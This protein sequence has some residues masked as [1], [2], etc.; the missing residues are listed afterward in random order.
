[1]LHFFFCSL[2]THSVTQTTVSGFQLI[3]NYFNF[4]SRKVSLFRL[5]CHYWVKQVI[6]CFLKGCL[7]T[8]YGQLK[9]FLTANDPECAWARQLWRLSTLITDC[10]PCPDACLRNDYLNKWF[11]C[12]KQGL[13]PLDVKSDFGVLSYLINGSLPAT[14]KLVS[15]CGCASAHTHTHTHTHSTNIPPKQ[16]SVLLT[17]VLHK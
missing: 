17:L 1:M 14:W 11:I 8:I 9:A 2:H 10:C 7:V 12:K 5:L 3:N 6:L 15:H 4:C 16:L 13:R